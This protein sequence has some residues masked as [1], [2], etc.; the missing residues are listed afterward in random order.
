[1]KP[2]DKDK[3]VKVSPEIPGMKVEVHGAGMTIR[4]K[5]KGRTN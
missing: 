3:M 4:G 1:M 5:T 2:F